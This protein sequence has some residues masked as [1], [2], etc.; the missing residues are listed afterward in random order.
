MERILKGI[1]DTILPGFDKPLLH[2]WGKTVTQRMFSSPKLKPEV[3]R[4]L[5]AI[6]GHIKGC[7]RYLCRHL[8][9]QQEN[10]AP[11]ICCLPYVL[12]FACDVGRI[13]HTQMDLRDPILVIATCNCTLHTLEKLLPAH[14]ADGS[15]PYF[16]NNG[17]LSS[18]DIQN[19][20]YYNTYTVKI[21]KDAQKSQESFGSYDIILCS[22]EHCEIIHDQDFAIVFVDENCTHSNSLSDKDIRH[23]FKDR[24]HVFLFRNFRPVNSFQ[25]EKKEYPMPMLAYFSSMITIERIRPFLS[26]PQV[27]ALREMTER[28]RDQRCTHIPSV[29]TMA[30]DTGMHQIICTLPYILGDV[31]YRSPRCL[32]LNKP[33][34]VITTDLEAWV[35]LRRVMNSH[36]QPYLVSSGIMTA[37][38]FAEGGHYRWHRI[39]D[40]FEA[41]TY[42]QDIHDQEVVLI[43]ADV[44]HLNGA[45]HYTHTI[46]DCY[47]ALSSDQFSA[48]IIFENER[49]TAERELDIISK[50]AGMTM[51]I[52][53]VDLFEAVGKGRVQVESKIST[54]QHYGAEAILPKL[55]G[56][57]QDITEKYLLGQ[58][59][60]LTENQQVGLTSLVD[61]LVSSDSK[62]E[63]AY[64]NTAIGYEKAGM[65]IW[66]LLPVLE[67][68]DKN[69]LIPD[70]AINLNKPLLVLCTDEGSQNMLFGLFQSRPPYHQTAV[71]SSLDQCSDSQHRSY[72][73]RDPASA[74]NI[75]D[76]AG[77][78]KMVFSDLRYL[79]WLPGDCFLAV[80]VFSLSPQHFVRKDH[81]KSIKE[82][83]I[84]KTKVVFLEAF[85]PPPRGLPL[86]FL[87]LSETDNNNLLKIVRGEIVT[88]PGQTATDPGQIVTDPGLSLTNLGQIVTDTGISTDP[89]QTDPEQTDLGKPEQSTEA[90]GDEATDGSKHS[91]LQ[92]A[93][94]TAHAEPIDN[95]V[96]SCAYST[97]T[98]DVIRP[99]KPIKVNPKR[100][101]DISN[102]VPPS[103][104]QDEVKREVRFK[105]DDQNVSATESQ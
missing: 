75:V 76:I 2:K 6:E 25:R 53:R 88:D 78:Y 69:H 95:T 29:I 59:S 98:M 44:S 23:K 74:R 35:T 61:W 31:A 81:K 83:F 64:V 32:S 22:I 105:L 43:T 73:I 5:L 17:F 7:R 57:N 91:L 89:G 62:Y 33:V 94:T 13:P 60:I 50:F 55:L 48:V 82:K 42:S 40:E 41:Y 97:E 54:I 104:Q 39:K 18:K 80:A 1:S 85:K 67:W 103:K 77:G 34:L 38:E 16:Q 101:L 70:G 24:T 87:L 3:K 52:F 20:A 102:L 15:R 99:S 21:A 86:P 63:P 36:S 100:M 11:I 93:A 27:S 72:I 8:Y 58:T 46:S 49:A 51:I 10:T 65:M 84:G 66:C 4:E 90:R 26:V 71:F 37:D 12:G 92:P 14:P 45:D 19:G 79:K 28:L 30:T 96:L 9:V 56:H 68:A 47:T